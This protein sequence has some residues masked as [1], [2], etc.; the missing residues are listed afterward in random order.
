MVMVL[1]AWYDVVDPD[2]ARSP[3]YICQVVYLL[4]SALGQTTITKI[5]KVVAF[6]MAIAVKRTVVEV[7]KIERSK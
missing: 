6:M 3:R 1:Q 5:K 7:Q 2:M 4:C